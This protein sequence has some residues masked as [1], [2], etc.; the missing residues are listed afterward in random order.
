MQ[1]VGDHGCLFERGDGRN[2]GWNLHGDRD[3]NQREPLG[4]CAGY[5]YGDG[6]L[7]VGF[8]GIFVNLVMQIDCFRWVSG[9]K[10]RS[11]AW[12][13]REVLEVV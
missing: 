2:N 1:R 8:A 11:T 13:S 5:D 4:D 12:C 10:S 6:E 7:K 3:G 9:C